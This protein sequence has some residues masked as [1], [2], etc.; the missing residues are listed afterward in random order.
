MKRKNNEI[1]SNKLNKQ[2]KTKRTRS[3]FPFNISTFG[4]IKIIYI[5][6]DNLFL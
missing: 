2:T 4:D 1:Q 3:S 5:T 6:A